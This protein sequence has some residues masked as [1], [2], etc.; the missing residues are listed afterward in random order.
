MQNGPPTPTP[1]PITQTAEHLFQADRS[2]LVARLLAR[3]LRQLAPA[4]HLMAGQLPMAA[5][6]LH[7]HILRVSL[8][9]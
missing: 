1:L 6:L 5:L 9:P 8:H 7:S 4:T 3:Q 2:Q